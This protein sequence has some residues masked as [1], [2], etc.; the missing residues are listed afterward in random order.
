MPPPG[1]TSRRAP[2][3][4]RATASSTRAKAPA[5]AATASSLAPTFSAADPDTRVY[6]GDCRAILGALPEARAASVDLVFADPPFNWSRAY[7]RWKSTGAKQRG[8]EHVLAHTPSYDTWDDA[9][10]R[11]DY[12][13]FTHQWISR[14]ADALRPGGALWINIPDD[15]AA[16]IVVFVKNTLRFEM[17]NWC[18][19]HYRFG[20]NR[21]G[22][23]INS[24]VH[25]LY[26]IKPGGARTWN[27]QPI[28]EPSDRASVY[29][30]PRTL[31]KRDGMPPGLR[32]PMDVWYGPWWGRVQGNNKERRAG[33]DNQLPEAYLERVVLSTSNPGDLVLD[34]FLGSGTTATV[35]RAYDRRFVGCEFSQA[36]AASAWERIVNIGMIDKGRALGSP[37]ALVKPRSTRALQAT[38]KSRRRTP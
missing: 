6:V 14:C 19:W 28:L 22:G 18:V 33:H 23:F 16:E 5:P 38:P 13:D 15:T 1:S 27:P 21:S 32:V 26:F 36:N 8:H 24:K 35:A 11:E 10:P 9:I 12:L 3:A 2:R 25:A 30:D 37:S 31:D 4:A 7:D 34:P 20:Q 29:A 17:A